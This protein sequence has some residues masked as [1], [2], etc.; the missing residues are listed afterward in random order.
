MSVPQIVL[1]D[2]RSGGERIYASPLEVVRADTIGQVDA[3]FAKL[4]DALAAGRHAAGYFS[5]ELGYAL[6]R[7]LV[8]LMP[9][10]R[11][12]PLLWFGIFADCGSG[13][14]CADESAPRTHAGRLVHEWDEA[15]HAASF[16]WIHALIAAGD[17][18][19]ANLSY[20]ARFSF[21]GEPYAFYRDLRSRAHARHCAFVDDGERQIVSI[22]PELFFDI[23]PACVVRTRPMKGTAAR[24]TTT[25]EDSAARARLAASEKERAE[26]LMIVDLV[27]NDL[28]RIAIPGSV[29]VESLFEVETYPTVHQLVSTVAARLAPRM[30]VETIVRALFPCGSVTGTPKIRAMEVIREIETSPRGVYCGAIGYFAPDGSAVF[31]VAIRTLTITGGEG[32]LGIGGAIVFDSRAHAEYEEC[33]V[34]ARFY[35]AA[36]HPLH[37]IETLRYEPGVGFLRLDRHLARI[38]SSAAAL[39]FGFDAACAGHELQRCVAGRFEALRVRL[40]L[41]EDGMMCAGAEPFVASRVPWRFAISPRRVSSRDPL[42]RHKTSRRELHDS[43]HAR[44]AASLGCD[45]VL[46]L[47]E[48]GELTEGSRTNIFVEIGGTLLT[49]AL[50]AGLLDGCLRRELLDEGRCFE[51]PLTSADLDRAERVFLGNSLRGLIPAI[52][53]PH[54]EPYEIHTS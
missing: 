25:E 39:G 28:S 4:E 51:A 46:F 54:G 34:K 13:G 20:R 23:S 21:V 47:N 7:R 35:E 26:N 1:D 36:H 49:P 40:T 15:R 10:S 53:I 38:A 18:Y 24:G 52:E 8:P 41:H 22:S 17:L 48:R 42:L 6:E 5:Y 30:G 12:V 44:L 29:E 32:E 33:R 43:E 50:T 31:N 9:S 2:P 3:A 19:Q 27:R 11:N 37:L 14:G 45:E 16:E